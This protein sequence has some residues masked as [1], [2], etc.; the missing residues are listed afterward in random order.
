MKKGR[1]DEKVNVGERRDEKTLTAYISASNPNTHH[2]SGQTSFFMKGY[3]MIK[4]FV[5]TT[6]FIGLYLIDYD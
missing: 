5:I 1:R 2:I 6:I 4:T 3:I